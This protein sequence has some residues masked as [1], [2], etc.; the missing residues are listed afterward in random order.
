MLT[1]IQALRIVV[2]CIKAI[3]GQKA[4]DSDKLK[5]V[6]FPNSDYVSLLRDMIVNSKTYGVPRYNHEIDPNQLAS[7]KPGSEVGAVAITVQNN[8]YP[9]TLPPV[10]K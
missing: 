3:S 8:A 4:Q 6:G 10:G 7:M 2:Q 1:P 5:D 9:S